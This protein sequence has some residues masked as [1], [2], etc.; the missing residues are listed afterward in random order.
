V[1]GHDGRI[2]VGRVLVEALMRSVVIEMAHL[3][4]NDGTGVSLVVD[5]QSVG[6]LLANAANEP[7]GIAVGSR[8]RGGILTTSMPS[9]AKTASK[10]AV[11][12][13]SRSRIR[14]RNE[15]IR[16]PRSISRLWA[17]WVVQAAVGW[18]VTPSR[19]NR[20]VRTSMAKEDVESAQRDGVEGE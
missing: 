16:C 11:N 9:E 8:R 7:L 2:M 10:V 4:V 17:A 5:Q 12:L 18:P 20:R 3:L 15:V 14:K 1:A 6:A 13:V 19:C